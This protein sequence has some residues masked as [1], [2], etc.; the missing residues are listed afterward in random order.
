MVYTL[1]MQ[2]V[3]SMD[4]LM[5]ARKVGLMEIWLVDSLA[6]EMVDTLAVQMATP[7]AAPL[8]YYSVVSMAASTELSWDMRSVPLLELSWGMPRDT[9]K[10]DYS[11]SSLVAW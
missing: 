3:V 7:K 11:D 5:A 10:V 9:Q 6:A 2:K 8:V 4:G 1:V